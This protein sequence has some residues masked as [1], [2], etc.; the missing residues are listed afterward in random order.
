MGRQADGCCSIRTAPGQLWVWDREHRPEHVGHRPV[1]PDHLPDLALPQHDHGKQVPGETGAQD[2][3]EEH[4][5]EDLH[6]HQ[7]LLWTEG[8]CC[9]GR[10]S[11]LFPAPT[12]GSRLTHRAPS[13]HL[14]VP[15]S[16]LRINPSASGPRTTVSAGSRE[17]WLRDKRSGRKLHS[18]KAQF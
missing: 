13:P 7:A 16:G 5:P 17:A 10:G 12:G 3:G 18:S 6:L 14:H 2:P 11:R 4:A 9:L 15:V 1:L 8:W